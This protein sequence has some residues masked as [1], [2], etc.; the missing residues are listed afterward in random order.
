[1]QLHY[2]PF[3]VDLVSPVFL[4]GQAL[5]DL[6]ESK[7]QP[8]GYASKLRKGDQLSTTNLKPVRIFL[9]FD[10][11]YTLH[12]DLPGDVIAENDGVHASTP[13]Q[14]LCKALN[15]VRNLDIFAVFLSTNSNLAKYSPSQR[16]WWS[17]RITKDAENHV[18]VPFVEL[19]FDTWNQE[20]LIKESDHF[21]EDVCEVSFMVR[22][23]RPL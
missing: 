9:Y 1:V 4:S 5:I 12:H 23:G 14:V 11:S 20:F 7:S 13:Y 18:Q 10:E 16:Y 8:D 17:G 2:T 6:I 3:I 19:P 22:F 15:A 21:L